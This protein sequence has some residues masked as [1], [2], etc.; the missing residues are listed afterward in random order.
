M[1]MLFGIFAMNDSLDWSPIIPLW[2]VIL[3]AVVA[4]TP[5]GVTLARHARVPLRPPPGD[6]DVTNA[7]I[8]AFQHGMTAA[9]ATTSP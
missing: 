3:L 8:G 2:L 7:G 6:G 4:G 1:C 5:A 9:E